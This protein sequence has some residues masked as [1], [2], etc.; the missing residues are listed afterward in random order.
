MIDRWWFRVVALAVLAPAGLWAGP[1]TIGFAS[2]L[3]NAAPGQTVTFNA[4]VAN[5]SAAAVS[6][7]SDALNVTAPLIGNDT[8]F[9]VNFPVS[10][11]AGQSVT[12][13]IFDVFVPAGA[14]FGV[15]PGRFA[16]SSATAGTVGSANFAVSVVPEPGAAAL[17]ALGAVGL[18][19]RRLYRRRQR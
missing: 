1:L 18:L 11:A 14:V 7:D 2:S 9:F 8:K 17:V 4:T 12:A 19:A 5:P 15:Y 16:I 13:P 3:L 10:L 6:L